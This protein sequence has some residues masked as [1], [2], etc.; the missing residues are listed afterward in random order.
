MTGTCDHHDAQ[1][2]IGIY[3]VEDA[4]AEDDCAWCGHDEP[5]LLLRKSERHNLFLCEE[6]SRIIKTLGGESA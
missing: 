1:V 5:R 3:E 4:A 6:C 2:A